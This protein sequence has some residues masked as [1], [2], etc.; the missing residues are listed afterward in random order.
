MT[1]GGPSG[2]ATDPLS[3]PVE[4]AY[5]GNGQGFQ[6][7]KGA[8][9][10]AGGG[11]TDN[12]FSLYGADT[13]KLTP[14]LAVTYG[15]R[16]V[17]D[18]VPNNSDL[19]AITQLNAW[20]TKLGNR[21]RQPNLNFAPQLGVA[22]DTSSNG[23]TTIR[24]G[25]GMFYDQSSFLNAYSDRALRLQAGNSFA[26]APA[27]IGGAS[28]SIQ[29]PNAGAPG[30]II[31][32]AGIVNANGSVSPYDPATLGSW[33]GESMGAAAPLALAL[34][35]A[36]QSG[37]AGATSNPNF[38]GNAAGFAS[39]M[40]NGLSLISPNYQT[41]RT[42]Q[43]NIGLRHEFKPGLVFAFDYFREVT[44]RTLLGVDVN[45]GGAAGTFNLA[46]ALAARDNAQTSNGCAA[47][48]NQV[49]S[50]M[51]TKL[52][53]AGALA[54]YGASGIGGPAQ[55]T[56][57][58]PCAFCA[59][60]GLN[61]NLGVNVVDLPEG[62]SVYGGMLFSLN[63]E[64]TNFSR[65]VKSASFRFSYQRS[66]N[67][68]QGQD[69]TTAML[70]TDYANPDRFTG[71]DGLD[72]RHQLSVAGLFNL[73]HSLQVSFLSRI[74]SPLPATLSFQQAAGGAEVLVTDWNGD[75][76]TGDIVQ[77]SSVG[78]FG[79]AITASGLANFIATYNA[80]YA[81]SSTPQTPAGGALTNAGVFSLADLQSMGG[82][83]QPLA[84]PVSH[85][86]GLG[87]AKTFD[88]RLGWE[89]KLGERVTLA[90]SISFYNVLNFA[91]FDMPG[92]TQ[93][94]I[95]GFGP[96][97]KSPNAAPVQPQNTVGGNSSPANG[98]TN[99]TTFQPNMNASGAPRSVQWGLEI[100]F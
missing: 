62:R 46:N 60:P 12:Q 74:A 27:C 99:R 5:L 9:G 43:A 52:G 91:N 4:W 44:T 82:V 81:T 16:W 66:R 15:A 72:R 96:S 70:A 34:Q 10:V 11:L 87:W 85:I 55:V 45:Q 64:I 73:R 38:I 71:P 61:P 3:Y 100:S 1:L 95:L 75:G 29:W 14:N 58:A 8:F 25:I 22:W 76:S 7:E 48:T 2:L 31:N 24:A 41:P 37:I 84:V 6:S 32:G 33:C 93:S 39:P 88:V 42:V 13:W 20:Q 89:H 57:G 18:T 23:T 92:Y 77:R 47:G 97:S 65:E 35:Q 68:G 19:P 90:P 59:F 98:R 56:G 49:T 78:S 54:A 28:G 51:V 26:T 40:L 50:C 17:R 83:L 79:R 67:V 80:S 21:V 63:Q 53:P 30:T 94:G 69:A 36:Y 86:A